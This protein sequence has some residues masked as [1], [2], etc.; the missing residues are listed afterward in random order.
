MKRSIYPIL[1]F[2]CITLNLSGQTDQR[3]FFLE[4]KLNLASTF[5]WGNQTN[6]YQNNSSVYG[7]RSAQAKIGAAVQLKAYYFIKKDYAIG[8]FGGLSEIN[9]KQDLITSR[10][11]NGL[12]SARWVSFGFTHQYLFCEKEKSN[13]SFT[14]SFS[15]D[16]PTLNDFLYSNESTGY[17]GEIALSYRYT[18]DY[19]FT[20]IVGVFFRSALSDHFDSGSF[21]PYAFGVSVGFQI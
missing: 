3:S 15:I 20:S 19:K 16:I 21:W 14:N 17:S 11:Y 2:V 5:Y 6:I 10:P 8:L 4:V 18:T 9:F 12:Y 1:I 13:F 7:I